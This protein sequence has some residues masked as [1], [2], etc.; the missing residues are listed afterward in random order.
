MRKHEVAA[1]ERAKEKFFE[2]NGFSPS[3]V[4]RSP[5]RV[6][7]IGEHTDYNDGFVLPIALPFDTAIA[8]APVEGSNVSV[9]SEGYGEIAFDL[10][11]DPVDTSGWGQ[12]LHG[13]GSFLRSS[14][15]PAVGWIGCIATDIPT[16]ANLSSSAAL[17]IASGLVFS[18]MANMEIDLVQLAHCGQYVE[19]QVLGLPSGIMDQMACALSESDSALLIDCRDLSTQAVRIPE[20][21]AVVVMDTGTRRELVGTEYADRRLEC[22]KAADVL[23]VRSLRE[24]TLED[25]DRLDT[26]DTRIIKRARHV[27]SEN[28][29]TE[30]AVAALRSDDCE[31]LGRLMTDSHMSLQFDFEVSSP[32][33]DQIVKVALE[34][35]GCFGARMTGGGF[36]G[37][38]IAL[39]KNETVDEFCL[40]VLESFTAP[41]SQPAEIPTSVYPVRASA[42]ASL[43]Q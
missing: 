42:G 32:A 18:S 9:F 17:E 22:E 36:A 5:G 16:G 37:C 21:A 43:I 26:P 19:N 33:L 30:L 2:K 20:G 23:G 15:K 4:A 12:Y 27:I 41:K 40:G 34:S 11:D 13:V 1:A 31:E 8:A 29:R 38:A 6:N 35:E 25:L 24:A 10:D 39:V 3:V 28:R 7:L 14:G